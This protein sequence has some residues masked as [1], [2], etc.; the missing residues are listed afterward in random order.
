MNGKCSIQIP[1]NFYLFSVLAK[2]TAYRYQLCS[3][4]KSSFLMDDHFFLVRSLLTRNVLYPL[5]CFISTNMEI[6]QIFSVFLLR[7]MKTLTNGAGMRSIGAVFSFAP[8][9]I[10]RIERNEKI[11]RWYLCSIHASIHRLLTQWF[12]C[13]C[14]NSIKTSLWCPSI[15]ERSSRWVR[16]HSIW[17]IAISI[18]SAIPFME[19]MTKHRQQEQQQ[20]IGF[21]FVAV[22]AHAMGTLTDPIHW[23]DCR[24]DCYYTGIWNRL[25]LFMLKCQM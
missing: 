3:V 21:S 25:E 18:A 11:T 22:V 9:T 14:L 16:W 2:S 5:F 1:F 10:R 20:K 4:G 23:Y 17:S 8:K 19:Y 13:F 24:K 15:D 6:E 12:V 7:S